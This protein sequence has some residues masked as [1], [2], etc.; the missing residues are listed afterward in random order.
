MVDGIERSPL[1]LDTFIA[2]HFHLGLSPLKAI[3]D[4]AG[5]E[6]GKEDGVSALGSVLGQEANEQEVDTLG[7]MPLDGP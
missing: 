4:V 2:L 1:S 6:V 5:N 7:L 3:L